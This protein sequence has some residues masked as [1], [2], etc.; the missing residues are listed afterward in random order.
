MKH[1]RLDDAG[2]RERIQCQFWKE[3]GSAEHI[4]LPKLKDAVKKEFNSKDDR[5]VKAPNR[6]NAERE[7]NQNRE[8]N[9]SLD[10]TT[11]GCELKN[12]PAGVNLKLIFQN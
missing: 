12:G 1:P 8:Q 10:S 2:K 11:C 4:S 9:K 6:L 3:I 7:E 5:L